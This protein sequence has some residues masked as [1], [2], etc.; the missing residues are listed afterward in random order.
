MAKSKVIIIGGGASALVAAIIAARNGAKVTI[1]ERKD[2]V[3][4]KILATGNGR[5]NMTNIKC[6]SSNFHG[7]NETFINKI[8]AQFDVNNTL[9]FFKELGSYPLVEDNGKVYPN[10][11]QA[12]S[13][14]DNLRYEIERLKIT[15]ECNAE[16][17]KIEQSNNFIVYTKD[18]K[19]YYGNKVILATGGKSTPDL[20]SNGSG[21]LLAKSLGHTLIKPIP[22]LVQLKSDAKFLKQIKG[23]KINGDAAVV[24]EEH[25]ILRKE[26]GEILFT[27][28]GI[29]GPPILQ[30]SRIA[31]SR[32]SNNKNVIVDIDFMPKV[33]FEQLDTILLDRLTAMPYKTIS[34]NF[35]GFVNKRLIPII[36]KEAGIE[37]NKKSSDISKKERNKLV[38]ILK[39]FSINIIGTNQWNQSQVTAGGIDV[40]EVDSNTLESKI[41]KGIYFAGEILDVD[42]DCGGFNLQ[43]AWSTGAIVGRSVC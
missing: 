24:D 37:I 27:D 14:L 34:D 9:E 16:V 3:G 42:G 10:S 40:N 30:L 29:S 2:R 18:N 5:C 43:W 22:S 6:T 31:S 1:L 38:S 25:N 7:G 39:K 35:I 13:I 17:I 15:V 4:K 28:Y 8:L 19:K 12:S 20:G 11:L 26:Y 21:Y 33:C 32:V 36:I 23:V 41:T